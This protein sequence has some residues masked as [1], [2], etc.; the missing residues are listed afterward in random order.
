M[1]RAAFRRASVWSDVVDIADTPYGR[2]M[3]MS[4]VALE[5]AEQTVL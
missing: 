4:S 1:I 5:F 2:P 3:A